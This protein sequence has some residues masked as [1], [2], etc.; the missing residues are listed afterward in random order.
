MSVIRGPRGRKGILMRVSFRRWVPVLAVVILTAPTAIAGPDH[1]F[2]PELEI[3]LAMERFE[4]GLVGPEGENCDGK[5]VTNKDSTNGPDDIDYPG[6][7][8][9]NGLGGADILSVAGGVNIICGAGGADNLKGASGY[10]TLYGRTG[11]D[12]LVGG[13]EQ[14]FL[15]GNSGADVV[16]GGPGD[17]VEIRGGGGEDHLY[18]GLGY[19]QLQAREQYTNNAADI[20]HICPDDGNFD[21]LFF[22]IG[23]EDTYGVPA[24]AP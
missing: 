4:A 2:D 23:P 12:L 8:I 9:A 5:P 24:C 17:D 18:D 3:D 1:Q 15:H 22:D 21:H 13:G 14:D 10:D 7:T 11:N 6:G 20:I 16:A 19:D